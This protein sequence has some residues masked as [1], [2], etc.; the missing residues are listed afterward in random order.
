MRTAADV[1]IELLV[2]AGWLLLTHIALA[3]FGFKPLILRLTPEN[4]SRW[5]ELPRW[6]FVLV[7]GFFVFGLGVF[8]AFTTYDYLSRKYHPGSAHGL[9]ASVVGSLLVATGSGLMVGFSAWK[10]I[11]DSKFDSPH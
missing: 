9:A 5:R 8:V 4:V 11:H 6:K 1:G 10:T 7:H 3:R 2:L